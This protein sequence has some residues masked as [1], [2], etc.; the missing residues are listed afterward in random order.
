MRYLE[1][2]FIMLLC[3]L[4]SCGGKDDFVI[5]C[6]IEG[7]GDHGVE[8]F[9][10]NSDGVQRSSFHPEGG[11]LTLR[12]SSKTPVLVEVFTSGGRQ[13]FN[14]VAADGDKLEVKFDPKRP[15]SLVI[16]GN[17]VSEEYAQF[18]TANHSLLERGQ[19]QQLNRLIAGQVREH[20]DRL[21]SAAILVAHFNARGNEM[22][23]DSLVRLLPDNPEIHSL[24]DNF[25]Q[26]VAA[27]LQLSD[28]NKI[29]RLELPG[30]KDS[31]TVFVPSHQSYGLLLFTSSSANDLT[32]RRRLSELY[33]TYPRAKFQAVEICVDGDSASWAASIKSDSASWKHS[34]LPAGVAHY[35]LSSL[36]IPSLPYFILT[37]SAGRQV[38]RGPSLNIAADSLSRRLR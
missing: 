11:K 27:Q 36:K 10:I 6:D 18:V 16:K 8:I 34:W 2:L 32:S 15:E 38:Y 1:V 21:S 25:S 19:S 5:K 13:L 28:D 4:S 29:G 35:S 3:L 20:P 9:Y 7:L 14:V 31:L 30:M 24:I 26:L 12:G 33:K 17:K 22:L 23:A 37:D